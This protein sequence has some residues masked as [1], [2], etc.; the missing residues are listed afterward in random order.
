MKMIVDENPVGRRQLRRRHL[1]REDAI[2]KDLET[3]NGG[4]QI[5]K[6]KRLIGKAGGSDVRRDGVDDRKRR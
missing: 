4:R 3:L 5:E 2:R 6:Q 1:R